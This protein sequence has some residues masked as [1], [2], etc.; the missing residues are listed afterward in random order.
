LCTFCSSRLARQDRRGQQL[1]ALALDQR[2]PV[3]LVG[4]L[5]VKRHVRVYEDVRDLLAA[6]S[7]CDDGNGEGCGGYLAATSTGLS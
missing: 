3:D 7:F 6:H 4:A 5:K 2:A 1:H